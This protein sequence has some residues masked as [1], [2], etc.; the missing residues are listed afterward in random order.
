MSSNL[1][2]V[3]R[4][5]DLALSLPLYPLPHH[6][7]SRLMHAFMRIRNP[8]IR[9][10]QMRFL[11]RLYGIDVSEAQDADFA[12][13]DHFNAFFTRALKADARPLDPDPDNL[14]SPVDGAVS[15]AGRIQGE[16]I[17]QAKGHE[18][19]L[20]ELLGGEAERTTPFFDG[21]FVTLYLSPRDYH[22]VHMPI[23]GTLRQMIHVPGRLFSVAPHTVRSVPRLFARNE[24]VIALFDTEIGPVAHILVGAIFV[25]SMDTVW[26]GTVTPPSGSYINVT[27][28]HGDDVVLERGAEMGRFNMGST[29]ITLFPKGA[30]EFAPEIVP[31]AKV[32]MGQRL[33]SPLADR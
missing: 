29:T 20:L 21:D 4:A 6:A 7:L 10:A 13:Y 33:A 32:R 16:S 12:S 9:T 27:H 1:S 19:S 22:R 2:L 17:F 31:G 25:S 30:I 15:Q 3:R 8:A 26:A 23:S 5:T 28:Y 24:R 18:Y 11:T 14:V